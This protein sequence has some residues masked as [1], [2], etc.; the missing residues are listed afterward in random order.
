MASNNPGYDLANLDKLEA[1]DWDSALP[2][3]YKY[4]RWK[5]RYYAQLGCDFDP[6]QLVDE[7]VARAYG[8]GTSSTDE[9]TYR[10]WNQ[11][12]CPDL[13]IFLIGIIKSM[14]SHLKVHHEKFRSE[15]LDNEEVES[16]KLKTLDFEAQDSIYLSGL[17]RP[18]TPEE[19]L[20]LKDQREEFLS[21]LNDI[22]AAD[23]EIA[24]V[25][26]AYEDGAVKASEVTEATEYEI[27][28]VYNI[29]KRLS[30]KIR[31][32]LKKNDMNGWERI[33]R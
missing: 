29:N 25:L 15:A 9:A 19:L 22:S 2:K 4:A 14:L 21:F 26:M 24:M 12:T 30:R 13:A 10:N 23:E 27:V 8:V 3:V 11:E 32:F 20:I 17:I 5:C 33:A 7:A 6:L 28:R 31:Q 18:K 16:E 1:A